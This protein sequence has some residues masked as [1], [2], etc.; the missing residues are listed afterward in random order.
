MAAECQEPLGSQGHV[1]AESGLELTDPEFHKQVEKKIYQTVDLL[2]GLVH[3]FDFAA[4]LRIYY[5][6]FVNDDAETKAK[7][8]KWFRGEYQKRPKR[9]MSSASA[10]ASAMTTGM[11]ISRS[12]QCF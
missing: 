6:S 7:V 3:G 11:S 8:I 9:K 2:S 10:S 4:L 5:Q 12:S 1:A